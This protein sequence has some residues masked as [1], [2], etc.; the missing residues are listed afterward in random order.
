MLDN[1]PLSSGLF[2]FYYFLIRFIA[3]NVSH[4]LLPD[5]NLVLKG[6]NKVDITDRCKCYISELYCHNGVFAL[7]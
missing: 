5:Y 4:Y 2:R 7:V 1:Y 3:Q 6:L